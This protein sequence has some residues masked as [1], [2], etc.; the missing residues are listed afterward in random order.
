MGDDVAYGIAVDSAGN[1]YLAGGT[2]SDDFPIVGV[3]SSLSGAGYD[4]FIAKVEPTFKTYVYA[5]Y[6]GATGDE[7][8][9]GMALDANN[10]LWVTGATLSTD[11]PLSRTG[12][13]RANAGGIDG[14]ISQFDP[15][16]A[17]LYSSYLGGSGDDYSSAMAM[18]ATGNIYVGGSTTSKDFPGTSSGFQT[19]NAG[20][21]DAWVAKV[22]PAGS[23]DVD[24]LFGRHGRR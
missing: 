6:L 10:N 4:G 11:F 14:F 18:D 1:V 2:N 21:T 9:F 7:L 15:A 16:G 12:V 3:S 8:I 19:A 23:R 22:S 5:G 17:L 13:Q 20:A 24:D